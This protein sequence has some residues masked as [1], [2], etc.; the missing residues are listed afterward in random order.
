MSHENLVVDGLASAAVRENQLTLQGALTIII[1]VLRERDLLPMWT[2][3]DDT[4]APLATRHAPF[5]PARP[6]H[7][8]YT[9]SQ[10]PR[11]RPL[12]PHA[13]DPTRNHERPQPKETP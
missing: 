12:V 13:D 7:T 1:P 5:I 4:R 8:A 6:N 10:G 11:R 3:T 9:P 2:K